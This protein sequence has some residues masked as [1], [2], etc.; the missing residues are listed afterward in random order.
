VK[1]AVYLHRK[2][3]ESRPQAITHDAWQWIP[4]PGSL[5]AHATET[6][7]SLSELASQVEHGRIS[8]FFDVSDIATPPNDV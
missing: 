7:L 4:E 1:L 6:A 3:D 2:L 8:R 5:T